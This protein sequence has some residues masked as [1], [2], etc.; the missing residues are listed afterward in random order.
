M[1]TMTQTAARVRSEPSPRPRFAV[2]LNA[3]ARQVDAR[4]RRDLEGLCAPSDLFLSRNADEARAI[5]ELV[6]A[7][8][9]RTVFTGGGDGTFVGWVNHVLDRAERVGAPAPRFG[10]LALGTGNAVAELVGSRP[11]EHL[12]QL[13]A[14]AGGTVDRLRKVDLL[15]C[16]GRR[17][18]F[19]GVGLDAAVLNDYAGLKARF[20]ST[21]L[22]GATSGLAGYF[23]AG[24]LRSAP[25]YLAER[26]PSYCEIVNLGR[27]AYRLDGRGRQVGPTIGH[28]ELIYAG[29]CMMAAA[30]TVPFYGFGL[31]AFPFA[32]TR[33]GTMQLRVA[34]EL[35]V[36]TVLWN[37]PRIWSGD[38]AHPG[39]LDFHAERVSVQF[40]RP[41]PLQVG[42]D[43]EGWRDN[44][45]F[46]L[47]PRPLE[48][49][50]FTPAAPERRPQLVH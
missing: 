47:T 31:R 16:D 33:P 10:V 24:A 13:G 32:G 23:L 43:A 22:R 21:A 6:V 35:S 19:A 34:A 49:V 15:T 5:A 8:R 1:M 44:V 27:A 50:D 20:A 39:L 30:S 17:T 29:P 42:G 41:M 48:I 25:R 37:L 26:R 38:F 11:A 3:N 28:G 2:L 18:P 45:T 12:A 46:G 36:P 9:Y 14:F 40:E 7:R 4:V